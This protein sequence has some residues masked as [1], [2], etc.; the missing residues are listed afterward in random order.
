LRKEFDL[1]PITEPK[2]FVAELHPCVQVMSHPE[3]RHQFQVGPQNVDFDADQGKANRLGLSFPIS[4]I[5]EAERALR[6]GVIAPIRFAERGDE[7]VHEVIEFDP[8]PVD[9]SGFANCVTHSLA[10]TDQSIFGLGRYSPTNV[11]EFSKT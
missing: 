3:T 1:Q 4:S 5:G 6:A 7:T 2:A 8:T 10:W 9:Y 11:T